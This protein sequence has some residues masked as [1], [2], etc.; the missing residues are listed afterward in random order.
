MP[1]YGEALFTMNSRVLAAFLF[2]ILNDVSWA[3][4]SDN[5]DIGS[6][7]TQYDRLYGL[8]QDLINGIKYI[9]EYPGSKG[10]PFLD[11]VHFSGGSIR[12][13]EKN[14]TGL[15]LAYNIFRQQLLLKYKNHSGGIDQIIL[16]N[17]H[18]PAFSLGNRDFEKKKL[19]AKSD[20]FYQVIRTGRI[21]CYFHWFKTLN[22]SATG[23]YFY[24]F[25]APK[26]HYYLEI[27]GQVNQFRNKGQFIKLFEEEHHR[28][29]KNHFRENHINLKQV[30]D[31]KIIVLLEFCNNLIEE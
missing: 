3:Q 28:A 4:T 13:G 19:D 6:V 25:S 30:N 24:V 17:R 15:S 11:E 16:R 2:I 27:D 8:N 1:A 22:Q 10:H 26:R 21:S 7:Y 31:R 23:E 14:Y 29:I 18:I 20:L 12:V 5:E 9:P